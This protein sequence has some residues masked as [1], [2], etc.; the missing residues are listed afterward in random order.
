ML[1]QDNWHNGVMNLQLND[2][3]SWA[4]LSEGATVVLKIMSIDTGAGLI[5]FPQGEIEWVIFLPGHFGAVQ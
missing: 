3:G 2:G 5:S 1:M 4:T